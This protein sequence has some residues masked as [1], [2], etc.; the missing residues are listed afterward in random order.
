MLDLSR[1][2][3]FLV[4]LPQYVSFVDE[5]G[6]SKD[7]TKTHLCLAGLLATREAWSVFDEK[8]RDACSSFSLTEPFHMKEFAGFRGDFAGWSD[9]RRKDLLGVLVA[10]M[11]EARVVPI[12]SVVE[13]AG[14]NSLVAQTARDFKDPHFLAFQSLTYQ[15]AVAASLPSPGAVTMVYAKHP[16][17]SV[18]L[19]NTADLWNAVREA[20]SIVALFMDSYRS[21]EAGEHAGLEAAD[22]WAYEL[23]K[24]FEYSR[25]RAIAPRWAFTQFVSMGLNYK[26]THDFVV[27]HDAHGLTG[28]GR[29]SRVMRWGELNL[30]EPGFVGLH[31]TDARELERRL[32]QMGATSDKP[33]EDHS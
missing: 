8:W 7:P 27:H 9:N 25:P 17:H 26:N 6:H 13:I 19:A 12:G 5:S 4:N 21:G 1:K 32:R 29:M 28:V 24:H 30:Y 14:Y 20:N 11:K 22:L 18:G 16:E 3:Q 33:P 2:S 15:I 10:L 23:R 31:P